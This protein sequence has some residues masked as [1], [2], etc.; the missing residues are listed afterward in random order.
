M[1]L[2][3][4]QLMSAPGGPVITGA[5][6]SG[7]GISID[8]STGAVSLNSQQT[9]I[10]LS[11]GTNVSLSPASGVGVITITNTLALPMAGEDFPP[12]TRMIFANSSAPLGWTTVGE[13]NNLAV[14]LNNSGGG[15]TNNSDFTS[16]FTSYTTNGNAT[17]SG[18]SASGSSS[19]YNGTYSGSVSL[20]GQ[21]SDVALSGAQNAN[22]THGYVICGEAIIFFLG[23][24]NPVDIRIGVEE[25][26]SNGLG[27]RSTHTHSPSISAGFSGAGNSHSH[28]VSGSVSDRQVPLGSGNTINLSVQYLDFLTCSL[29]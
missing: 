24:P 17:L 23:G 22:H 4:C 21:I 27:P 5:V 26:T 20:N 18:V 3:K 13:Y 19:T 7:N 6:K 2:N 25:R 16:I 10:K 11:A 1:P 28:T 8:P 12:G 14:R 15:T 29:S 9:L